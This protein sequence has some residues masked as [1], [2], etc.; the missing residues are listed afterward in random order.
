MQNSTA[1]QRKAEKYR[2]HCNAMTMAHLDRAFK[3][4]RATG[5]FSCQ[6]EVKNAL[7]RGKIED[8]EGIFAKYECD[9]YRLAFELDL[10]AYE[11]SKP[12]QKQSGEPTA[13]RTPEHRPLPQESVNIVKCH[14]SESVNIVKCHAIESECCVEFEEVEPLVVKLESECVALLTVHIETKECQIQNRCDIRTCTTCIQNNLNII[15][16]CDVMIYSG[17]GNGKTTFLQTIPLSHLG[18]FYDTDH[19][20]T[21][22]AKGLEFR[23]IVITNQWHLLQHS[24]I[25]IIHLPS[26]KVWLQR[27]RTKCKDAPISWY[28]D[29]LNGIPPDSMIIRS[30]KYLGEVVRWS[31]Q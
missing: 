29:L 9:E 19:L 17:P 10:S 22:Q 13:H 27:C 11:P 5:D 15:S 23:S 20:S 8:L 4:S 28:T 3:I 6:N 16:N 1:R 24:K 25:K 2:S 14:T 21:E 31:M 12:L 18:R 26:P 30:D 7:L